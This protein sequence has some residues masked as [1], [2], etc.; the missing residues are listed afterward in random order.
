M[1][2]WQK[3]VYWLKRI[4]LVFFLIGGLIFVAYSMRGKN[5][6]KA[7][8]EERLRE[9]DKIDNKTDADLGEAEDL[10]KEAKDIESS[11]INIAEIYKKKVD[12]LKKQPDEPPKPGDAGRA[13]DD[14]KDAWK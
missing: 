9:I 13:Y 3:I 7:D 14:L 2:A 6:R 8:I 11:I 12:N 4:A 5:K 1:T 10:R